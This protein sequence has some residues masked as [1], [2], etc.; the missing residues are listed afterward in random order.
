MFSQDLKSVY[1]WCCKLRQ[2]YSHNN[3]IWN[4]RR[5]WDSLKHSFLSQMNAG[6]Y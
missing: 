3:D 5:H 6:T 2:N 1:D 4:I